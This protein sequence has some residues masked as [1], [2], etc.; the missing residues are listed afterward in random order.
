MYI[1]RRSISNLFLEDERS[2]VAKRGLFVK[3]LQSKVTFLFS[4]EG[5]TIDW[6]RMD[7]QEEMLIGKV[8]FN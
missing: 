8:N 5:A 3:D 6:R 1:V 2:A 4:T 7:E